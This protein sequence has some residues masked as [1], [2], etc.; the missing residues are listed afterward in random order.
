VAETVFFDF[1]MEDGVVF[2][3]FFGLDHAE[4]DPGVVANGVG[5]AKLAFAGFGADDDEGGVE[6]D[7]QVADGV[8]GVGGLLF[9]V[10][11]GVGGVGA[12]GLEV[13]QDDELRP[14]ADGRA[15]EGLDFGRGPAFGGDG[16]GPVVGFGLW[17]EGPS[18][19]ALS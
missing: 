8:G 17:M 10:G 12:E 11:A 9:D 15:G 1:E 7:G 6:G 16:E 4:P 13:V 3:V 2:V 5:V 19:M 14:A 18:R